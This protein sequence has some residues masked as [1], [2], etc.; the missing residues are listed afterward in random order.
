MTIPKPTRFDRLRDPEKDYA[1][2]RDHF[3]YTL[4]DPAKALVQAWIRIAVELREE[5]AARKEEAVAIRE[6]LGLPADGEVSLETIREAIAVLRSNN[7]KRS[8]GVAMVDSYAE[9][10]RNRST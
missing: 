9:W 10:L 4:N 3:G 1:T 2:K 5:L 7:N 8:R 6:A